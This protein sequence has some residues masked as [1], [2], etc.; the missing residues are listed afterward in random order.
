MGKQGVLPA[1]FGWEAGYS[2]KN[3]GFGDLGSGSCL[4]FVG[5]GCGG[6]AR[7]ALKPRAE[8]RKSAVIA[9]GHML[10]MGARAVAGNYAL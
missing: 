8:A 2:L 5:L 1:F 10:V 9:P 7:Q 3:S 4:W 6:R